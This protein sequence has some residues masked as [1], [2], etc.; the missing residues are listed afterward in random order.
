MRRLRIF[1]RIFLKMTGIAFVVISLGLGFLLGIAEALP[2]IAAQYGKLAASAF[3][4]AW[5]SIVVGALLA[6]TY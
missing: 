2:W 5:L 4:I 3:L 6:A 1:L